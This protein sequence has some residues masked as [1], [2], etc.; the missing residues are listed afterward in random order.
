[1]LGRGS[2]SQGRSAGRLRCRFRWS[3]L[4]G[5]AVH[6]VRPSSWLMLRAVPPASASTLPLPI[7]SEAPGERRRRKGGTFR[8]SGG[9]SGVMESRETE[10]SPGSLKG[11]PGWVQM[12]G[13]E[14]GRRR[15][16]G[17]MERILETLFPQGSPL[18]SPRGWKIAFEE[19]SD[20]GG[21]G[22]CLSLCNNRKA[23]PAR[24]FPDVASFNLHSNP[25]PT[26]TVEDTEAQLTQLVSGRRGFHQAVWLCILLQAWVSAPLLLI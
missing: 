9:S 14:Q 10:Q 6:S 2:R 22:G 13:V 20:G 25:R 11:R 7:G 3:S 24:H 8:E 17:E 19:R 16:D 15:R 21:L 4:G 5:A 18:W 23:L 12:L 26:V 1:M